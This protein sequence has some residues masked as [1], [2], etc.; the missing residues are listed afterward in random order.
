MK[1][2]DL[3]AYFLGMAHWVDTDTTVDKIIAG[4]PE[5]EIS[6]VL[7]VWQSTL[8]AINHAIKNGYDAVMTHEPTFY[9]HE[10]EVEYVNSLPADSATKQMALRKKRVI[11]DAKLV[12]LRNHDVWDRFPDCGIPSAW[13]RQLGREDCAALLQQTL[14]EEKA[15]DKK[16]TAMAEGQVNRKAA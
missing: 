10:N 5:K 12:I 7:V 15:T 4:D 11:E 3:L 14:D 13:A 8:E 16:L 9:C 1:A 2:K 6:K